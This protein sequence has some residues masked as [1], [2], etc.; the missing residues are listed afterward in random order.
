[1]SR[2]M[3]AAELADE[4]QIPLKTLYRWRMEGIGPRAIRVGRHLRYERAEVDRWAAERA[5]V[6]A[7]RYARAK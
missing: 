7:T 2:F 3:T 4:F 5:D 6:E 1:V